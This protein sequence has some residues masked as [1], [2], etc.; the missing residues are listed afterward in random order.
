MALDR[1]DELN[2]D[3]EQLTSARDY[4]KNCFY[5]GD[6][7]DLERLAELLGISVDCQEIVRSLA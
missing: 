1:V 5:F 7:P 3:L 4:V 2:V 6:E